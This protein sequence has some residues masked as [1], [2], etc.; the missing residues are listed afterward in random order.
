MKEKIRNIV[1]DNT[2]REGKFFDENLEAFRLLAKK[3]TLIS[4][5]S[6]K[7]R[8]IVFNSFHKKLEQLRMKI[9]Y[10]LCLG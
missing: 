9:K 2:S 4:G 10:E 8:S 1:E 6:E 3:S 7:A 5:D